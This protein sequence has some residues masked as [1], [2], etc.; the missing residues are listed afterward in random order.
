MVLLNIFKAYMYSYIVS[1]GALG[2][3]L[4]WT[5]IYVFTLRMWAANAL[6]SLHACDI[7]IWAFNICL[8]CLDH[9]GLAQWLSVKV[10]DLRARGQWFEPFIVMFFCYYSYIMKHIYLNLNKKNVVSLEK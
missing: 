10:F 4:V 7:L 8:L 3:I 2:L 5:C 9:A 6:V 1:S